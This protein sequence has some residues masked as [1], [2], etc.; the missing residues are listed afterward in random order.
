MIDFS[1]SLSFGFYLIYKVNFFGHFNEFKIRF[2]Y[3]SLSFICTF[4]ISYANVDVFLFIIVKFLKVDFIFINLFEGFYCFLFMTLFLTCF[5][6]FFVLVY[7]I[8]EFLKSGLTKNEKTILKFL[9]K[10]EFLIQL[11]TFFFSYKIF[12]PHLVNFLLSFEQ[13]KNENFFNFFFQAR[14]LD[15]I[16]IFWSTFSLIFFLFQI[17]FF[18]FLLIQF[19]LIS[20]NFLI[21]FRREFIILFLFV[22]CIFSPPD[23]YSQILLAFPC[24]FF[25]EIMVFMFIFLDNL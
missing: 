1:S 17:P 8:F 14:L 2:F 3:L 5:F 13:N 23:L 10:G 25:Y 18:I 11:L 20:N 24:F 7:S 4:F 12:L 16:F 19:R 9:I 21:R 15:Y 6:S 22:G